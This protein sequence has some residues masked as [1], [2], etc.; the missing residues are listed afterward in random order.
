MCRDFVPLGI[1]AR[2][3]ARN[4]AVDRAALQRWYNLGEGQIYRRCPDTFNEIRDR[5]VETADL[6]ALEISEAADL[7]AAVQYLRRRRPRRHQLGVE[8]LLHVFVHDGLVG[9]G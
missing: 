5:L 2:P 7:V 1:I 9:F 4:P 6:L 3:G 8:L